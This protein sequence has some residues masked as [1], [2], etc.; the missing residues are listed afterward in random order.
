MLKLAHQIT[1]GFSSETFNSS[2]YSN[3]RLWREE[4]PVF[5]TD[6]GYVYLTRYA[7][8]VELLGNTDFT[9]RS[10]ETAI[11]P[12]S[13]E[14]RPACPLER[15]I[16]D[17]M[18]FTDPPRHTQLRTLF[19]SHF[20]TKTIRQLEPFI[21][22]EASSLLIPALEANESD[23][24]HDFAFPLPVRVICQILGIPRADISLFEGWAATLTTILDT[25]TELCSKLASDTTESLNTYFSDLLNNALCLPKSSLVRQLVEGKPVEHTSDTLVHSFAF[26]LWAGHETTKAAI[27]NG[28][29]ILA[30]SP[31]EWLMLQQNPT[32]IPLAVE[33]ILRFESP[34]Q[35]LSRWT[36][37]DVRFGDYHI[38]ANSMITALT[39]AANRDPE[40]FEQ[41]DTFLPRR[42]SNRHLAF[43]TGRHN[44]LG[45]A[46]ARMEM[47]VSLSVMLEQADTIEL[48]DYH[49]RPL[50]AF[51]SLDYLQIKLNRS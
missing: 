30:E 27:A 16:D 18:V 9:R 13:N 37:K 5:V 28:F 35:K 46:L 43:G 42:K 32:R 38:P 23:L 49:W 34:L 17:W 31:E 41:A 26:L 39:G 20:S 40:I 15:M 19:A 45:A 22:K 4:S 3:Y 51:R 8:C 6:E 11:S 44:C 21:R 25:G 1:P 50:S 7:D 48:L 33:E 47:R 12:F 29:K 2:I 14:Q 10:T 24:L 36:Q